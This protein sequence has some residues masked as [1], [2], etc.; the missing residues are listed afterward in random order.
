MKLAGVADPW[1]PFKTDLDG[2]ISPS[3]LFN[4]SGTAVSTAA[5]LPWIGLS[6]NTAI[7]RCQALGAGYDLISYAQ[8]QA[9]ALNVCKVGANWS[10]GSLGSGA[11]NR[12]HSQGAPSQPL[13][14]GADSTPCTGYTDGR[15][16]SENAWLETKRTHILSNGEVV[17]DLAGNVMEWI[18]EDMS[19]SDDDFI[20]ASVCGAPASGT[21]SNIGYSFSGNGVAIR[22]GLFQWDAPEYS[23]IFAIDLGG[24]N[25][26]ADAGRDATVGFRCVF[27]P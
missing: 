13:A 16:C 20:D 12:G 6:R 23:G 14:A 22:G 27:I 19:V 18:K 21:S 4:R 1:T 5:G 26:D 8:S 3:H 10:G 9:L 25:F 2:G 15:S 7:T 17:W 11:L 24:R